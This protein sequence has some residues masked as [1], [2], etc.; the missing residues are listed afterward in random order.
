MEI[1]YTLRAEITDYRLITVENVALAVFGLYQY[2]PVIH[3]YSFWYACDL[4][5]IITHNIL[6]D[7][8]D[9]GI[10]RLPFVLAPQSI[11]L[12]GLECAFFSPVFSRV[13]RINYRI[14]VLRGV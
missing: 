3:P 13:S 4:S 7:K 10:P 1:C 6:N 11:A 5:L 9:L 8:W 12:E 14:V 2:F